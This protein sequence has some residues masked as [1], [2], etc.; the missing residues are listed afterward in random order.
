MRTAAATFRGVC[1]EVLKNLSTGG[2][3]VHFVRCIRSDLTEKPGGFQPE[4]VRQQLRALAVM[5]TARAR[6]NGYSYRVSFSDFI[7]R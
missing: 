3:G 1:L 4:V 2:C 6:Q 5:D 7:R